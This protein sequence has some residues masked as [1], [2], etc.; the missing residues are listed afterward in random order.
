V[1]ELPDPPVPTD[2]DLRDFPFMPLDIARL[3]RSKA[4]L[5]AKRN[6]ALAFYMINLW[7][8]SWHDVPAGSLK[9]DD[10]ALAEMAM[11][12]PRKWAK[13]RADALHGWVKCSDGRLYHPVI[14]EKV[15]PAWAKQRSRL[16]KVN[17]RHEILS[18]EWARIRAE[19]FRRDDYTCQYCGDR[20]VRLEADHIVPVSRGGQTVLENLATACLP[21]NRAKGTK[22]LSEWIR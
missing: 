1:T 5:K 20:G 10:T 19:V 6:P 13:V 16:A 22:L 9:D 15:I 3:R 17:R 14:A 12:D 8:A 11:C 18:D 7:T 4:W 21:C 2:C